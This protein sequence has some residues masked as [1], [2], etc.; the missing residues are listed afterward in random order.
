LEIETF[1]NEL[2]KDEIEMAELW[3]M[4]G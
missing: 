2:S 4:S 1:G 3:K